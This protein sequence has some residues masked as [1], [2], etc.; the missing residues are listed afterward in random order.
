ML[1]RVTPTLERWR[2]RQGGRCQLGELG[3]QG[4][5]LLLDGPHP[6]G[7]LSCGLMRQ[8]GKRDEEGLKGGGPS[9]PS[10]AWAPF[11]L[12]PRPGTLPRPHAR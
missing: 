7:F 10:V 6:R 5:E 9:R 2:R 8:E 1:V 4:G 11:S 3:L 12:L